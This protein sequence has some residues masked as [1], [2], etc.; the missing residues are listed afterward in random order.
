MNREQVGK[1]KRDRSKSITITWQLRAWAAMMTAMTTCCSH[2]A[3]RCTM[4]TSRSII[5]LLSIIRTRTSWSKTT[6]WVA[7]ST[8]RTTSAY[9]SVKARS[10]APTPS[11]ELNRMPAWKVASRGP[12]DPRLRE[13]L[14]CQTLDLKFNSSYKSHHSRIKPPTSNL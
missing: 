2:Q 9:E 14:S 3:L 7:A 6:S 1:S 10:G 4:K 12:R 5:A 13:I 11:T 8:T